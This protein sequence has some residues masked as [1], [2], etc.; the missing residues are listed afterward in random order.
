MK[1]MGPVTM[2]CTELTLSFNYQGKHHVLKRVTEDCKLSSSKAIN[3]GYNEK[4]Q[5]FMLQFVT[6]RSMKDHSS[7]FN[8]LHLPSEETLLGSLKELIT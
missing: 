2:D 4:V 7:Q 5:L 6:P 1:I 3:K 8:A